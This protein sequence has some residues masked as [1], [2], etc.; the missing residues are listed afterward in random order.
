MLNMHSTYGPW[1][2][3]WMWL[4]TA[5]SKKKKVRFQKQHPR[6]L[7]DMNY[8]FF[9]IALLGQTF[10]SQRWRVS[11]TSAS[12]WNE[13]I[14]GNKIKRIRQC[15]LESMAAG[16]KRS[17]WWLR[18]GWPR[19]R[20]SIHGAGKTFILIPKQQRWLYELSSLL[21][22]VNRGLSPRR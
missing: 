4:H 12:G 16:I 7:T 11:R 2:L 19:N 14:T 8:P 20:G 10:Y 21:I 22:N 13:H 6:R 9:S 5:G 18:V 3:N 15:H 17:V 1:C